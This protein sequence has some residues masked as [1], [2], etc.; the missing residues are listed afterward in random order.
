MKKV[1]TIPV[2]ELEQMHKYY[3]G[4][5]KKASED[6]QKAREE[7]K[8]LS[9]EYKALPYAD[10]DKS[11]KATCK[12]QLHILLDNAMRDIKVASASFTA[13]DEA[14]EAFDYLM[15]YDGYQAL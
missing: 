9:D 7:Y 6:L 13:Y 2:S 8:K 15:K 3:A 1:Q 14:A 10:I 4:K 12:K 11:D 5:M